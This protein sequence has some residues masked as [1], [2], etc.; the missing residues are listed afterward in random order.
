MRRSA[1][2]LAILAFPVAILAACSDS[3]TD[4]PPLAENDSCI[5]C[6]TDYDLLQEIHTPDSIIPSGGCSGPPPYF[7]PYD[8]VY[9]DSIGFASFQT[10]THGQMECTEC[11]GGV[12]DTSDKATAHSGAFVR[13]P[14]FEDIGVCAECHGG[15]VAGFENG[16]HYNGWGQ[17]N[18][19][20][21]R[22]GVESFEELHEGVQ[23]GYDENCAT[24]HASCGSCHVNRPLAGGGGLMN[25]HNFAPPEMRDNCTACHSSRGGHAYYGVGVGTKPDVH[26][27]K[28]GFTC[29]ECHSTNE[30]HASTG[31]VYAT[32]YDVDALP[33]CVDCHVDLEESN[34]YHKQHYEQFNC[35]V[36]HSQDYNECGSC[37]VGGEGARIHSHQA[38]KIG[39]NPLASK[40]Y[41]FS[42]VRRTLAAPDTWEVYG[43]PEL[44]DFNDKALFNYTS[45][46]GI[47]R[48]TSRTEVEESGDCGDACHIGPNNENRGLYLFRED[49]LQ[50]WEKDAAAGVVVDGKLPRWWGN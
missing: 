17:R 14:S 27:T 26:L 4:P 15:I 39:L 5:G 44:L 12:G 35:Q 19:Q 50:Q 46:H 33:Q 20:I 18:S 28:A 48:W 11:H 31:T 29:L 13:Y 36:C 37:H 3:T 16:L 32:R 1:F 24:C 2:S 34:V 9:L 47:L 49:L 42:T 43:L 30:M 8:R 45:P 23:T 25:G 38:F 22:A 41:E 6:H 40:P 21:R 10:T 7:Q